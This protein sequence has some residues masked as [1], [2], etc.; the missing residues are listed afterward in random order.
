M[1]SVLNIGNG[2]TLFG[3]AVVLAHNNILRNVNK[4]AGK[5]TGV[6]STQSGISKT[7]TR[8]A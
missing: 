8:T 1:I 3:S 6:G 5:I 7:F 2:K 4:T